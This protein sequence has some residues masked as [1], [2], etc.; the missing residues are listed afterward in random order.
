MKSML[1]NVIE[2][3]NNNR[4]ETSDGYRYLMTCSA[5]EK[6]LVVVFGDS[7]RRYRSK[8]SEKIQTWVVVR[9]YADGGR[10]ENY[11]KQYTKVLLLMNNNTNG[12]IFRDCYKWIFGGTGLSEVTGQTDTA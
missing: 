6:E 4:D 8:I 5:L 3:S 10:G 11:M 9:R 2:S 12:F 7:G 1:M